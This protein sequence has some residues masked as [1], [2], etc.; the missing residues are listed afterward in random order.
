MNDFEFPL[1]PRFETSEVLQKLKREKSI[2]FFQASAMWQI[3]DVFLLSIC[4]SVCF[5]LQNDVKFLKTAAILAANTFCKKSYLFQNVYPSDF[6][7]YTSI[8]SSGYIGYSNNMSSIFVVLRGSKSITDVV[9]NSESLLVPFDHCTDCRVDRDHGI[10]ALSIFKSIRH[11]IR[12]VRSITKLIPVVIIGHSV[13]GAIATLIASGLS[14][15]GT[16][17]VSL[18]TFGSPRVGNAEFT[19][20]ASRALPIARVTHFQDFAP[21]FPSEAGYAHTTGKFTT[22]KLKLNS[23]SLSFFHLFRRSVRG[24]AAPSQRLSR[25]RRSEVCSAMGSQSLAVERSRESPT[26]PWTRHAVQR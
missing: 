21:H 6:T 1:K 8:G 26:V 3:A 17:N 18:V 12:L 5:G 22:E 7:P 15:T 11:H 25:V 24:R 19:S 20:F 16:T 23:L 2:N 9:F 10:E 13:G 4:I 14:L